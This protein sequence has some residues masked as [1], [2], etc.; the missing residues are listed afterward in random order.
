MYAT[1]VP[2]PVT[3]PGPLILTSLASSTSI[4]VVLLSGP[5]PLIVK[6]FKYMVRSLPSTLIP[7]PSQV[8][9]DVNSR[10]PIIAS[11][12]RSPSSCA[13]VSSGWTV[14]MTLAVAEV[15][16]ATIMM[17]AFCCIMNNT[18]LYYIYQVR[19]PHLGDSFHNLTN[20]NFLKLSSGIKK[21]VNQSI[22]QWRYEVIH[23]QT[24]SK[25]LDRKA[26]PIYHDLKRF[27]SVPF[28]LWLV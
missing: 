1:P 11:P 8:T 13:S 20:L 9:S 14:K 2:K 26:S 28:G 5:G 7:S 25:A 4:P 24:V 23:F 15:S 21:I 27:L 19:Y 22:F 18:L 3:M 6:P 10:S 17:L 16:R 12:H